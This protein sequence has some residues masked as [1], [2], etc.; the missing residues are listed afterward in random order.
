MAEQVSSFSKALKVSKTLPLRAAVGGRGRPC[1]DRLPLAGPAQPAP[2]EQP[3][4]AR[5]VD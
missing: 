2:T 1:P 4:P 3:R 5:S